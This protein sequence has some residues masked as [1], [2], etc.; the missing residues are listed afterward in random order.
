M[1]PENAIANYLLFS[2]T[3]NNSRIDAFCK[4]LKNKTVTP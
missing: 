3:F 4:M 1:Q 2:H